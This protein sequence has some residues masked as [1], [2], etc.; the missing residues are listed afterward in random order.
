MVQQVVARSDA[1]EHLAHSRSGALLVGS[2]RRLRA[3]GAPA[4]HTHLAASLK[5][6][7]RAEVSSASVTFST[8]IALPMPGASTK[9]RVPALFFCRGRRPRAVPECGRGSAAGVRRRV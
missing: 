1:V 3:G 2:S 8:T 7:S 6:H 5:V 9:R 4:R